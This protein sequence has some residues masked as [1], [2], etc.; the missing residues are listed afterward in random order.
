MTMSAAPI[1]PV[2]VEGEL[3]PDLSRWLWI[4]KWVLALPHFVCLAF[5]WIAFTAMTVVAFVAVLFTGRYPRSLYH[6]NVGVLR[7]TWRVGFYTVGAFATDRYPPFTL[8]D[9]PE[10]PARLEIDYPQH[11]A[12]GPRL[13]GRWLLGLPHYLI[14]AA[15]AGGGW[16]AWHEGPG[17]IG[18]LAVIAAVV[19]LFTGRYPR[20]LFDFLVGLN[21][22][23]LRTAAYASLLTDTY[24]PFRVDAGEHEPGPRAADTG[25]LAP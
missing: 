19:L 11:L 7:W 21:R 24:P 12:R 14:A 5:L 6:F 17:L 18:A 13:I 20:G 22:W 8:R 15:F 9:V 4:V 16:L 2:R 25:T 1:Y 23:V 10:Y 3:Q